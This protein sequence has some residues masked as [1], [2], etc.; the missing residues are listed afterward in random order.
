MTIRAKIILSQC[1]IALAIG[2]IVVSVLGALV[3]ANA[4]RRHLESSYEQ[5]HGIM[6]VAQLSNRFAEQMAELLILGNEG[7]TSLREAQ[8]D[9]RLALRELRAM[10]R[11]ELETIE[12]AEERE[13]ELHDL[14]RIEEI[15]ALVDGVDDVI[16]KLLPLVRAG[17]TKR[18]SEIFRD[19]FENRFDLQVDEIIETSLL[20]E[21]RE[22]EGAIMR[23]TLLTERLGY[24][25]VIVAVLALVTNLVVAFLLY[26]ALFRPIQELVEGA[27]AVGRGDLSHRI[28][29]D[30]RDELGHT[31]QRFNLMTEQLE[32][33]RDTLLEAQQTLEE[34]VRER[35]AELQRQALAL[36]EANAKLR[37]VDS[38][39]IRF[40]T[41]VSHELRTPLTILRGEAEVALRSRDTEAG[42]Y[43]EVLDRIVQKTAQVGM[44]VDD[45][46]FLARSEAGSLRFD[47]RSVTMQDLV[48]EVLLDGQTLSRSKR[49][50][51]HAEQHCEPIVVH[52]DPHRI[53]QALLT[54]IDNAVKYS[55]RGSDV[56]IAL[57]RSDGHAEI[58]VADNGPGFTKDEINHAFDRFYRG[59][60]SGGALGKAA[61]GAGLGLSIA[62][63][64]AEKHNGHIDLSSLPGRGTSLTIRLPL[65]G[66][67]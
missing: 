14:R 33:Q 20:H 62:K 8:S 27:A 9:V 38:A 53:K 50:A 61:R 44:L 22:V 4:A 3:T 41:D 26:R 37:E 60:R 17:D 21:R 19:E 59:R 56:T 42:A 12:D 63:W 57:T 58:T 18:A 36:A 47:F 43:R 45:L 11:S 46:L 39:R 25:I 32:K 7:T 13:G 6:K 30:G 67:A 24:G 15:R 34:K 66:T 48:A 29:Y 49:I 2:T 28:S 40:L 54:M 64:I 1:I 5:L 52:G 65:A 51:I 55:P 23:S 31:A 10:I 16:A 35:T